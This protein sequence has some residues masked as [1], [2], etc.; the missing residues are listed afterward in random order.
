MY[1]YSPYICIF[2]GI[3]DRSSIKSFIFKSSGFGMIMAIDRMKILLVFII[4]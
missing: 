4:S 2:F 3:H 1:V